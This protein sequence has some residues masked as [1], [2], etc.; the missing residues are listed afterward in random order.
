MPAGVAKRQ[1]PERYT[2]QFMTAENNSSSAVT[3]AAWRE[4]TPGDFT[5][6]VTASWSV[7]TSRKPTIRLSPSRGSSPRRAVATSWGRFSLLLPPTFPA[8]PARLGP[9]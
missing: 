6:T 5:L 2:I 3:L 8:E 7:P 1:R 4:R 9:A